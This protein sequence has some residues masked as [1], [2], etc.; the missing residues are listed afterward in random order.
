LSSSHPANSPATVVSIGDLPQLVGKHLGHSGWHEISQKRVDLFAEATGDHQWIHVDPERAKSG[1][2]KTTVAHGYLTLSM[3]VTLL[4]DI[5]RVD[6]AGLIVNY[7]LNKV[8]FPAPVPVGSRI[9]MSA[10]CAS[11]DEVT[12]GYQVALALAFER[13]G[14]EKPVCVAESVLRYHA[15][16]T[17]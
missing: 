1:P 3:S 5:L 14:G 6:G 13:E 8:R 15:G 4:E 12:G 10:D 9:R 2:F 7:G 17:S 16:S 11:V